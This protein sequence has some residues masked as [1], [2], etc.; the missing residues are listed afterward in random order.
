[1]AVDVESLANTGDLITLA[2]N[3]VSSYIKV[4]STKFRDA[5]PDCEGG[6]QDDLKLSE[7]AAVRLRQAQQPRA[8]D[9]E[10]ALPRGRGVSAQDANHDRRRPHHPGDNS[11]SISTP[12]GTS[13][14]R[15]HGTLDVA[16][17]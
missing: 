11:V 17:V 6:Q 4:A 12:P 13:R 2:D 3:S 14:W 1:M 16:A 15:A 9:S 7:D 10:R 8:V 5:T